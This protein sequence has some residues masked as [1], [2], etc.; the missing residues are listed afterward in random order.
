MG[1]KCVELS[2]HIKEAPDLWV[3]L[4][5]LVFLMLFTYPHLRLELSESA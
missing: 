4:F 1:V 2:E 3:P 5:L